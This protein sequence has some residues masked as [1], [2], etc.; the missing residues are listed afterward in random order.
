M[1][2]L[3]WMGGVPVSHSLHLCPVLHSLCSFLQG[4]SP[5]LHGLCPV[6][7][8]RPVSTRPVPVVFAVWPGDRRWLPTAARIVHEIEHNAHVRKVAFAPSTMRVASGD[9]AGFVKVFDLDGV[10][11]LRSK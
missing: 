7:T 1:A 4:L 2:S 11:I 3:S 5:V 9:A 10:G 8:R 6:F